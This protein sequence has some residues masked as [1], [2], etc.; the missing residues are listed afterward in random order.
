MLT[1]EE[2]TKLK[3]LANTLENKYQIGKNGVTNNTILLLNNAFEAHEL[4]KVSVLKSVDKEIN[5][6]V[7]D[8]SS[9]LNCEVVQVVG[10]VL[11]LY[12][13]SKRPGFKHLL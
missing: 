1:T 6:I 2:K 13:K 9:N 12:R 8:L 3:F 5:E 4:I 7:L 11:T 10:R